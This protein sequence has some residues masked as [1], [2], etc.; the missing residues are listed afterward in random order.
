M[1]R[2]FFALWPDAAARRALASLAGEVAG[3]SGGRAVGEDRLHLTL[4][5]LGEVP[6]DRIPAARAAASGVAVPP[7]ELSLDHIGS[8]ART[9]VAWAGVDPPPAEL[10]GLHA[11]LAGRL[12]EAG[13]GLEKRAFA[14]H[15]TLARRIARPVEGAAIAP[16]A[17]R[18]P[19][20]ALVQTQPGDGAYRT[21]ERW[22]L[23]GS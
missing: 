10:A 17:W 15:L 5:F 14:A 9:G 22:A 23:R 13:F 1:A 11:A 4:V 20:F 16:I 6:R 2:L 3:R 7:F 18:V 12:S 21:L 19:E 8:F